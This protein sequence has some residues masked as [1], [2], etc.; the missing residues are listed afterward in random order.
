MV[1]CVS[2]EVYFLFPYCFFTYILPFA[3]FPFPFSLAS[4]PDPFLCLQPP[5]SFTLWLLPFCSLLLLFSSSSIIPLFLS[6]SSPSSLELTLF[7][8]SP[9][10]SFLQLINSSSSLFISFSHPSS[11]VS[12]FSLSLSFSL[13]LSLSLSSSLTY[14]FWTK[15]QLD[16]PFTA[17]FHP[18][19]DRSLVLYL[20]RSHFVLLFHAL[21]PVCAFLCALAQAC[22]RARKIHVGVTPNARYTRV[23]LEFM[24]IFSRERE[25]ERERE[26]RKKG[27][28][29][30]EET[31]SAYRNLAPGSQ[32]LP[33]MVT[34]PVT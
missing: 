20:T 3:P 1:K 30:R 26:R 4:F 7:I 15:L 9:F 12:S 11:W 31:E 32:V 34:Y 19:Q 14:S 27:R 8:Y 22:M 17:R 24:D 33:T 23:C 16:A 10:F 21:H 6:R 5:G 29:E 18:P 2:L 25:R 13:F 28:R